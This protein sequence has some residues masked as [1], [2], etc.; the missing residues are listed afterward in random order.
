MIIFTRTTKATA[1]RDLQELVS[2]NLLIRKGDGRST[3]YVLNENY[4][5]YLELKF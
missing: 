1:T 5:S 2:H 3:H 4:D